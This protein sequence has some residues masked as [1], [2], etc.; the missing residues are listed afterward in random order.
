MIRDIGQIEKEILDRDGSC[1][2]V[3]IEEVSFERA[4]DVVE[5]LK[6]VYQVTSAVNSGGEDVEESI[7]EGKIHELFKNRPN[8]IHATFE[9]EMALVSHMQLYL[10]W[11]QSEK[12]SVEFT[13]FPESVVGSFSFSLF[14]QFIT[15]FV[16]AS[17]SSEYFV[18]YENA[19]WKYGDLSPEGGVIYHGKMANK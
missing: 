16:A 18:R 5:S 3:D 9:N 19:S 1:R 12:V 10:F 2:D 17:G 13:F 11:D 14:D 15:R 4:K 6:Q 7:K 8:S